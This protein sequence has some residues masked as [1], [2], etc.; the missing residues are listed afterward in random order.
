MPDPEQII[1]NFKAEHIIFKDIFP[2]SLYQQL[3]YNLLKFHWQERCC[4][5]VNRE[6]YYVNS[7]QSIPVFVGT[8]TCWTWPRR[9]RRVEI[10]LTI[11]ENSSQVGSRKER[12]F[13]LFLF[14]FGTVKS[15][16][17]NTWRKMKGDR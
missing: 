1:L 16:L 2:G 7:L 9:R 15:L 8:S 5:T 17:C 12:L 6:K 13:Q 10:W 11:Q 3:T 4:S 14:L